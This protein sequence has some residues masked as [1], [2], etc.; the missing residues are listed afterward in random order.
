MVICV[1]EILCDMIAVS[2]ESGVCYERHAGGAPFNVACG[3]AKLT[4]S[5]G[6]YGLVGDDIMG[7]FLK[8]FAESIGFNYLKI[9]ALK[10]KNTTLAF[11]DLDEFGEREFCF[12]RKHTADS[13]FDFSDIAEI[14]NAADIIHLGSLPLSIK[15]GRDFYDRL[16]IAAREK[17]K[18]I[19]FDVNYRTD[20]FKDQKTAKKIYQKYIDEA[21]I[22]KLSREELLLFTGKADRMGMESLINKPNKAVF[23][24][25]G[26]DGSA[27]LYKDSFVHSP[28]IPVQAVDTTGAGD[29]FFAGVL[30][31]VDQCGFA[32][33]DKTLKIGN[34]CGS[35]AVT[36]KGAIDSLPT[37]EDVMNLLK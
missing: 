3:I 37:K 34:V 18:I 6:F 5:A 16:I 13:D 12:Y 10:N 31:H 28:V 32:D 4:N 33:L 17:G 21:D 25:M 23:V 36:R 24:T 19:S 2:G 7:K 15:R 29:A 27:C 14:V 30:S 20:V 9:K 26:K 1:G 8:G 22:V 35:L 11:V